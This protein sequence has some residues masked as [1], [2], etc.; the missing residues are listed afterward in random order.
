MRANHGFLGKSRSLCC[1][2]DVLFVPKTICTSHSLRALPNSKR[3]E[4][5]CFHG[6]RI[7]EHSVTCQTHVCSSS[8]LTE[9]PLVPKMPHWA[10]T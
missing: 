8:E 1:S 9:A 3:L 10:R 5:V 6:V 2:Q 7:T 4:E